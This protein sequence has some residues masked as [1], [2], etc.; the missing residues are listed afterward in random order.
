[1]SCQGPPPHISARPPPSSSL[2][3]RGRGAQ[4]GHFP[5][6]DRRALASLSQAAHAA[7]QPEWGCGPPPGTGSC[8]SEPQ[9]TPFFTWGGGWQG[10]HGDF[11]LRWYSDALAAHAERLLHA[12]V[13]VF[14][15]YMGTVAQ[16]GIRARNAVDVAELPN[17]PPDLVRRNSSELTLDASALS[18]RHSFAA[19]RPL[20]V[21][22]EGGPDCDDAA[23]SGQADEPPCNGDATAF[24]LAEGAGVQQHKAAFAEGS[25]ARRRGRP[26][27][28]ADDGAGQDGTMLAG[29]VASEPDVPWVDVSA[30]TDA[31]SPG[32][33]SCGCASCAPAERL[34]ESATAEASNRSPLRVS[35]KLA[36]AMP[37]FVSLFVL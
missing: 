34:A 22:A 29:A 16:L 23:G 3:P 2:T 12:A 18:E 17:E 30:D 35:I 27:C 31:P 5:I 32:D 13:R 11:F 7:G 14:Y 4:I 21:A 20:D 28:A 33:R 24:V 6:F 37:S 9:D 26:A 15:P 25:D 36:G 19:S 8:N 10:A 1:M